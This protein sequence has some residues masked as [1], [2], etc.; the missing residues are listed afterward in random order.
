M[1]R[2]TDVQHITKLFI[3][4]TILSLQCMH[5]CMK[6]LWEHDF[7]VHM[8]S[9]E[10]MLESALHSDGLLFKEAVIDA[11]PFLTQSFATLV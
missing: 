7:H 11:L 6:H 3:R 1:N 4:R 8:P 5:A 9:M 10:E 2:G